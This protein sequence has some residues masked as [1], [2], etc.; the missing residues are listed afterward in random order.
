MAIT[1]Y[2]GDV[3]NRGMTQVTFN[4]SVQDLLDYIPTFV[5]GANT[6]EQNINDAEA[7]ALAARTEAV[8]AAASAAVTD[9]AYGTSTTSLAIGTGT[10]N[11]TTQT[12]KNFVIGMKVI[13]AYPSDP[14]GKY[15]YGTVLSYTTGTGALSL[16]VT[17]I[18]GTG[19]YADWSLTITGPSSAETGIPKVANEAALGTGITYGESKVTQDTGHRW[20]WLSPGEWVDIDRYIAPDISSAVPIGNDIR[21][22][23]ITKT[24]ANQ[25]TIFAGSCL[26]STGLIPL[27]TATSKTATVPSTANTPYYIFVVKLVS[28][29]SCEFRLYTTE[30]A[31]ESDTQVSAWRKL[32]YCR[33]NGSNNCSDFVSVGGWHYNILATD[34]V[35]QSGVTTSPT[36]MSLSVQVPVDLVEMLLPGAAASSTDNSQCVFGLAATLTANEVLSSVLGSITM[37]QQ[38]SYGAYGYHSNPPIPIPLGA[39]V[40]C[41]SGGGTFSPA[42]RAIKLRR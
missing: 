38:W 37:P 7:T 15:M 22:F 17:E 18:F 12:G 9:G 5:S 1:V 36:A 41:K 40:Y 14:S 29:G 19:T 6:T 2:T 3:P 23:D 34:S 20:V 27:S 10:K 32:D 31:I 26:D 11:F 30:A 28:D 4:E 39:T 24:G 13:A 21:G 8:N 25:I 42:V 35:T 16:S 33:T